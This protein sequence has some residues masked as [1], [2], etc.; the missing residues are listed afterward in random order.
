MTHD[1]ELDLHDTV[2]ETDEFVDDGPGEGAL[3]ET[4]CERLTGA[5]GT[6]KSY[7]THPRTAATAKYG[8]LC[9]TPGI[10]AL[11]LGANVTTLNSLLAYFDTTS[12]SDAYAHRLLHRK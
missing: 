1:D 6:G 12:M 10:S 8:L 3:V 9:S 5:A 2:P 4:P 11:N 7:T